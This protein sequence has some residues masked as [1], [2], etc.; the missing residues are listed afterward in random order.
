MTGI[1]FHGP[2]IFDSGWAAILIKALG[3]RPRVRL[4][5]A[6]TMSRAALLD[7]GLG[8]VETPGLQ[9]SQCL[10][11]LARDCSAVVLAT[12]G[13]T[14][15]SGLVFGALVARRRGRGVPLIQAECRGRSYAVHSGAC[16]KESLALEKA[17]FRRAGPPR[18]CIELWKEDGCLR[19]R[20]TTA[21]HGDF[22][23]VDGIVVGRAEAAEIIFSAKDRRITAISGVKIK[24]HGLEKLERLGGVDLAAAKLASTPG[25]RRPGT[26]ARAVR[27]PGRGV[28]FIDHAGM[29]VFELAAGA[30]GAVTVGDDTTAVAGDILRR[31]G[32]PVI[33]IMD[34]DGDAVMPG[35]FPAPGSCLL[36]VPSD[37]KAGL[38]V[39]AGVFR[40]KRSSRM[41]F[42]GVKKA[43]L[44]ILSGE[45]ISSKEI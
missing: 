5:S 2:E 45:I 35:A 24:A 16:G 38:A 29:H 21:A 36:T 34:G 7:S 11:L 10:K 6:G 18:E 22:V 4:M 3:G 19:R 41:S 43:V 28:C 44:K 26:A 27:V 14:E 20:M 9:P 30:A 17:G 37:D 40:G 8:G 12:F 39:L 25:L 15:R 13:K 23:L 42:G 1:L 32:V 31:F 33:G